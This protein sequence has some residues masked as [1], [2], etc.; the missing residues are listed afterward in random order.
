MR[1]IWGLIL[2][3]IAAGSVFSQ[4]SAEE[5]RQMVREVADKAEAGDPAA[6]YQLGVICERGF[7]SI[8]RDSLR[9]MRLYEAAAEAGDLEAQNYLGFYLISNQRRAA[10][11]RRGLEWLERAAI[12][13]DRKA[14]SNIGFLLLGGKGVEQDYEKA[15]YWLERASA[16]GLPAA[17]S[18]LGDLYRDGKGVARDSLQAA[19]HYYAAFD[20]GLT[21]AAY[22]LE[23]LLGSEWAVLPPQSSLLR[24]CISTPAAPPKWHSPSSSGLPPTP[25]TAMFRQKMT[26]A[27]RQMSGLARWRCWVTHIRARRAWR[28][29][30]ANPCVIT[31][32]RRKPAIPQR[33]S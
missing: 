3:V 30:M 22:K 5:V 7:D 29:T 8:P 10:D 27:L 16:A 32:R 4:R 6:M 33:P 23:S 25:R 18:M 9:A 31:L 1:K 2:A 12:G 11:A 19:A 24:R 26:P 13:G 17:S 20:A 14:Q 28:M 15:A 21:D